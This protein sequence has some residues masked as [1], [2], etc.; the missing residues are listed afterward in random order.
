MLRCH[1][2]LF[3]VNSNTSSIVI[4]FVGSHHAADARAL[5]ARDHLPMV[6]SS[7]TRAATNGR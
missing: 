4:T 6:P 7:A 5:T 2:K 3:K 1:C